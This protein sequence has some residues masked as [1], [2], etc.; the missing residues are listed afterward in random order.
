M[1]IE[2][3]LSSICVQSTRKVVMDHI[4]YQGGRL[5]ILLIKGISKSSDHWIHFPLNMSCELSLL[6]VQWKPYES[7]HIVYIAYKICFQSIGKIAIG[8]YLS[9]RKVAI[10]YC[11][12]NMSSKHKVNCHWAYSLLTRMAAERVAYRICLRSLRREV[13]HYIPCYISLKSLMRVVI[14]CTPFLGL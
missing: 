11:L 7:G 2:Y 5:S 1:V 14:E 10:V 4:P 3:I 12:C 13:I 6:T 8:K 9:L